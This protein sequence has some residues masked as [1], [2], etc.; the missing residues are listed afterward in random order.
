MAEKLYTVRELR[1]GLFGFKAERPL[2]PPGKVL[3][4]I[5]GGAPIVLWPG[6]RP[7]PG[8][9]TWNRYITVYEIEM[10][11]RP[12]NFTANLPTREL[13]VYF[14]VNCSANYKIA[15]PLRVI[16]EGL[17]A[18]EKFL[19][20]ILVASFSLVTQGFEVEEKQKAEMAVRD[21]LARKLFT[22]KLPFE[23]SGVN[24]SLELEANAKEFLRKRRQQREA[25]VIATE[26][27]KL[28]EATAEAEQLKK[29]YEF[30]LQK[31]QQEFDLQLQRQQREFDIEIQR[32]QVDMEIEIQRQR[33]EIYRPMIKDGLWGVLVQQLAQNPDD[34]DRV[35]NMILDM[36]SRQLAADISV[37]EA[38]IKGDRIEDW[39]LKDVT[40][41]LVGRLRRNV[42]SGPLQVTGEEPKQLPPAQ[43][44]TAAPEDGSQSGQE[45]ET[46]KEGEPA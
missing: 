46:G 28:T 27:K 14:Q 12:L 32:R 16:N 21:V 41:D 9:S 43:A 22:E 29:Q 34:I 6:D 38:M 31:R 33:A 25:A 45:A 8:E 39:H 26:G 2:A 4:L 30:E 20:D 7:T 15:D 36:H 37:L 5:G 35:S 18:P 23:L 42:G 40:T 11:V 44:T 19:K 3:V 10:G 1:R 17:D 13:D 24:V